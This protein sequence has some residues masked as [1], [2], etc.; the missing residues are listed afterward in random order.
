MKVETY[1]NAYDIARYN[2]RKYRI[3]RGYTQQ[4]LADIAD[5]SHGFIRA[6]ES[7]KVRETFSLD[8]LER[9]AIALEIDIKQLFD[10][11]V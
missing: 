9:I 7:P 1:S 2:I 5:L 4:Q 11:K 3:Q 8:T 10:E 6:I